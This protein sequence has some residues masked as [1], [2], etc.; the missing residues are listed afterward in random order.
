ML[1]LFPDVVDSLHEMAADV[2]ENRLSRCRRVRFRK[3]VR[4]SLKLY[5]AS[6]PWADAMA[7]RGSYELKDFREE[8]SF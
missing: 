8:A 3:G 4:Q 5:R 6:V 7:V 2:E 1:P